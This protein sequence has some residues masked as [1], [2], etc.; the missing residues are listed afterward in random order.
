MS[1]FEMDKLWTKKINVENLMRSQ[2]AIRREYP[3]IWAENNC[4]LLHENAP[5]HRT[6]LVRNYLAKSSI[7][8]LEN[9]S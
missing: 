1:S 5:A 4:M 3:A 9:L 2:D 8:M 7:K 6:M